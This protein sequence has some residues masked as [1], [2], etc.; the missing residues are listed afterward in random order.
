MKVKINDQWFDSD[1]DKICIIFG[2]EELEEVKAMEKDSHPNNRVIAGRFFT[3]QDAKNW[4][5]K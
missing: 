1:S 2:D 4:A 5:D 3:V